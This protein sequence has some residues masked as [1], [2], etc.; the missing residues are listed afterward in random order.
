MKLTVLMD[1]NTYIDRYFLGEPAVSYYIEDRGKKI[2]FDAGY[3]D[4]FIKNAGNLGVE[5]RDLDIIA[6]SHGHNDHT[7]G[8][9]ELVKFTFDKKPELVAHSDALLLKKADG[10]DIGSPVSQNELEHVMTINFSN[11]PMKLTDRLVYLGEIPVMNEFEPRYS[12]GHTIK[13]GNL[14][15][16]FMFDD[17][18]LAYMGKKGLYIVTG[19]SHSGICNIISYAKKITGMDKIAGIIGG[20]HLFDINERTLKTMEYLSK[21]NIP[22]MYPCH[23][24]SFT[25]RARLSN[26][27][28]VAEVGVGLELNWE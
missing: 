8:L 10:L 1:N 6:L 2:L 24:T 28:N 5:L 14:E 22:V 13:K 21:E 26:I 12:I 27:A 16:D 20:F 18:A 19:C 23:C 4:A 17:T 15:D 9:K 25:V 11:K 7:G 3:S